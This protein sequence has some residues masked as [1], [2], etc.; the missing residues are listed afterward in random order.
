MYFL[1]Q[2]VEFNLQIKDDTFMGDTVV[3]KLK[4]KNLSGEE[5]IIDGHITVAS[6]YYTGVHY[7]D[8]LNNEITSLVLQASEGKEQ[9]LS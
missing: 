8:I 4:V 5:R 6:M 7:Q 9:H 1:F 3:V 2:D